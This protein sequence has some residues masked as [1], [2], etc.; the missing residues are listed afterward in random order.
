MNEIKSNYLKHSIPSRADNIQ[1]D[2]FFL[3]GDAGS[4]SAVMTVGTSAVISA[5]SWHGRI[6]SLVNPYREQKEVIPF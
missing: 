4:D 1:K 6:L 2:Q 3:E 5:G